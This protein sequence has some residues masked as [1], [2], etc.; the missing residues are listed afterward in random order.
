[1]I[2]KLKIGFLSLVAL[3]LALVLVLGGVSM[4]RAAAGDLVWSAAQTVDLSSPD[5]NLTIASGSTA[6]SLVV[7][8]GTIVPT[9]FSGDVFTVA[10]AAAGDF[11][12]SPTTGVII[13]CSSS[14]IAT[15]VITATATQAYTITPSAT[16]CSYVTPGGGGG[17]VPPASTPT[18]ITPVTPATPAPTVPSPAPT[19]AP[20]TPV[21]TPGT[22]V[23]KV[24]N[25]GK[26]TL[27]NGSKGEPV[28]EL[29]RVLNK[30]LGSKLAVDGKLGPKTIAIIKKWQKAHGLKADGL[31][32][33]K[34]K[35]A[36]KAEAEKN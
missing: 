29:Q 30:I 2:K 11:S 3:A 22:T 17:V 31:V 21:L 20:T 9:L 28:K 33:A 10:T 18:A 16:A 4:V 26:V 8:T 7:N 36:M 25:L 15:A 19:P 14:N 12:I 5:L 34:T 27:K 35:A 1:M 23:T 32:G 24:Y 13:T 6:S